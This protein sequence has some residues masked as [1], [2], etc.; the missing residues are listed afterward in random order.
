M[1]V[2]L[3]TATFAISVVCSIASILQRIIAEELSS[4]W[5]RYIKFA[6]Y[7][8]GISGGV[9]ILELEKYLT[10]RDKDD[11]VPVLNMDRWVLE[12]YRTVIETLQSVA[13]ALLV[14]FMVALGAYVFLRLIEGSQA[15]RAA[16]QS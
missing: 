16:A 4:A 13:W 3:L 1:F 2:T 15:K 11:V 10:P 8:V 9:R 12:V 6:I 7:V 14:F 5:H